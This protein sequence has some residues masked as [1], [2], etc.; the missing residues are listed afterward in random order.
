[1]KPLSLEWVGK[2]EGD[3]ATALRET[4]S[5]RAPN[6]GA[7]CFHAQ[8]CAEKYLKARL[9]EAGISPPRTHSLPALLDLA[10]PV[11]PL[12]ELHREGLSILS[13]YAVEVRYPGESADRE[14]AKEAIDLIKA[15][16]SAGR[17]SL[18][19]PVD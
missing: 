7:A 3:F 19:L 1:M 11:E 6:F 14:M 12:W 13:A 5:R 15:F 10:L 18:G 2:A 8:Q 17:I 4:R 9:M 16:I